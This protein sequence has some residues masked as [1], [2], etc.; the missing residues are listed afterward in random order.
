MKTDTL[1][2]RLRFTKPQPVKQAIELRPR[3]LAIFGAIH[4]HGPLPTNYLY[5][6]S[7]DH[8]KNYKRHQRR[9]TE[10]YNGTE[11]GSTYLTRPPQQFASFEARYQPVIYD[12][13]PRANTFLAEHG[14]LARFSPD[15]TDPF[16]HR[17]MGACV[18]ASVE[19]S[20]NARGIRYI[21]MEE[22]LAR[23]A[24][25]LAIPVLQFAAQK[26]VVPDGLFGLE[27]PGGK[28]RFFAVEIDRHTESIKRR[29]SGQ[30]TF[31]GKIDGYL[32]ILRNKTY[33]AHWDIPNLTVLTVTTNETHIQ[34]LLEYLRE[35]NDPLT[36]RFAFKAFPDF[37]SN[38]KVPRQILAA[39]LGEPHQRTGGP[40]DISQP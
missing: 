12:L 21:P 37:G 3:D 8:A 24:R 25:G 7:K 15:R 28:F 30:N 31:G 23:A 33:R 40:F 6:F 39:L 13:A 26:A 5:E 4:R 18:S 17:F 36:E 27:Y 38:W 1:A 19:L 10:L 14:K 22:I 34:N 29:K 2:R 20:A 9:L 16:L 35:K 32:D 11:D